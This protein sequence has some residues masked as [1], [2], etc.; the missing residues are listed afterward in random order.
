VTEQTSLQLDAEKTP[1]H[2]ERQLVQD[3]LRAARHIVGKKLSPRLTKS[4]NAVSLEFG[5]A[6]DKGDLQIL[7][8]SC[9]VTHTGLLRLARREKCCGIKVETVDSLCDPA[10]HRFVLKATVYPCQGSLGFVGYGDAD[11]SNVSA[12]VRGAEL[13]MAETRAVNRALRKAYGIGLCSAE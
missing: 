4:L 10:A 13:R 11:P 9:Y 6:L 3:N 12:L 7:G 2:P 5:F 8:G 1:S